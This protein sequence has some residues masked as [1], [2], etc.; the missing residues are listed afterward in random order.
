[1]IV[2]PVTNGIVL[3]HIQAGNA[4]ELYKV[5]HLDE[6]ECPVAILKNVD[7]QK[8]GRKDIMKIEADIELDLDVIG[9][10]DP[11]VTVSVIRDSK[12]VEK[13]TLALPERLVNV[14]KCKNP[15]CITTIEQELDQCFRL[16]NRA[17]KVYRC[18]YCET[19]A[20]F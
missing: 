7:S 11:D 8:M 3:D 12:C 6:L 2:N 20:E 13:L 9:F 19:K 4:M 17:E 15:R 5:L 1:M 18:E 16:T 10:V 14:V